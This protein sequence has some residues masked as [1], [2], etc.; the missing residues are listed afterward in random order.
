MAATETGRREAY[1]RLF[2]RP[3]DDEILERIRFCSNKGWALGCDEFCESVGRAAQR[4]ARPIETG[5]KKGRKRGP[6][7]MPPMMESDPLI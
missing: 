5:W 3:L 4:R 2:D 6:R 7:K 1:M